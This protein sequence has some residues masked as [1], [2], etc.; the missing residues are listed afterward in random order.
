[1]TGPPANAGGTGGNLA[2]KSKCKQCGKPMTHDPVKGELC[3]NKSCPTNKKTKPICRNC[4]VVMEEVE[5]KGVESLYRCPKCG[6]TSKN[7]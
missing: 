1:M 5:E 3:P 2:K 7:G 6:V 4:Q